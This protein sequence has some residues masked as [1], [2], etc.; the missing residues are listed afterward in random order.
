MVVSGGEEEREIEGAWKKDREG[1]TLHETSDPRGGGVEEG[2]VGSIW[3]ML[4]SRHQS[5]TVKHTADG[6]E[7][8]RRR[9]Q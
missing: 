7:K 8:K 3:D 4:S 2:T 9:R 6:P 5:S 1:P